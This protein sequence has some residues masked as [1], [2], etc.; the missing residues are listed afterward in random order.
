[1][2]GRTLSH[3]GSDLPPVPLAGRLDAAGV[4]IPLV[5]AVCLTVGYY[6][7]SVPAGDAFARLLPPLGRLA[8]IAGPLYAFAASVLLYLL[9][10]LGVLRALGEPMGEYGLGPGRWRLG[11]VLSGVVLAVMVPIVLVAAR[12]P[13]F[14]ARYPLAPA[15]GQSL[16]LFVAYE[17][18]YV[19][20]FIAW[21]HTFRAFLLVG[22]YRRI[23]LHAV[24]VTTL[25]F[26]L[27]HFG[28]PEAETLGSAVAGIVLAYLA[29][30]TRSFWWGALVHAV[31]AVV[32]DAAAAWGRLTAG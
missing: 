11:L 2:L 10:P 23:G 1:M 29:L 28:K 31:V 27:V 7:G 5:A 24:S 17:T 22:L 9:V 30:R 3:L 13:A 20:Y 15:A 16:H 25:A 14:A 8:P 6:E 18:G 21:E 19:A 32:M 4:A 26:V 12:L